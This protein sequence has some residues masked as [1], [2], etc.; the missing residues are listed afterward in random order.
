MDSN[1]ELLIEEFKKFINTKAQ[2]A[3][4]VFEQ[5][6]SPN[7]YVG[8]VGLCGLFHIDTD[9]WIFVHQGFI[10]D[11]ENPRDSFE[12][13]EYLSLSELIEF[14]TIKIRGR[15]ARYNEHVSEKSKMKG[16]SVWQLWKKR[17]KL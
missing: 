14:E 1:E 9:K 5:L 2:K 13:N 15:I 6:S 11:G 10:K 8:K 7:E 12:Q 4:Y 3:G 16:Y 17:L